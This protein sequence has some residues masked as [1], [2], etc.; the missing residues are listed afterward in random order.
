MKIFFYNFL[1]NNKRRLKLFGGYS[2]QLTTYVKIKLIGVGSIYLPLIVPDLLS[3][4]NASKS[5][6]FISHPRRDIWLS[7]RSK[8]SLLKRLNYLSHISADT[9]FSAYVSRIIRLILA[10][11]FFKLKNINNDKYAFYLASC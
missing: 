4:F 1:I 2:E 5:L 8:F 10:A 7:S 3:N 6:V 11:F 9:V